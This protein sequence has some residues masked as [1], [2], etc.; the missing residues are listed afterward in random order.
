MLRCY[1]CHPLHPRRCS[2]PAPGCCQKRFFCAPA[3]LLTIANSPDIHGVTSHRWRASR[4]APSARPQAMDDE[5]AGPPWADALAA[6]PLCIGAAAR[7]VFVA[8]RAQALAHNVHGQSQTLRRLPAQLP[9]RVLRTC[10]LVP[11][12]NRPRGRFS[13]R[14]SRLC[15]SAKA[16]ATTRTQRD[17]GNAPCEK[18]NGQVGSHGASEILPIA[19]S[20]RARR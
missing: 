5:A 7:R 3:G 18:R 8:G 15:R 9:A 1:P 2:I 19:T 12:G 13:S 4:I 11:E 6:P 20:R 17:A 10:T 16:K 14:R